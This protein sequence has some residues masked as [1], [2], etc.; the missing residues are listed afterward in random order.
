[1]PEPTLYYNEYGDW[2]IPAELTEW[3]LLTWCLERVYGNHEESEY[4]DEAEC[5]GCSWLEWCD[6]LWETQSEGSWCVREGM[7]VCAPYACSDR[8]GGYCGEMSIFD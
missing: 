2:Y 3:R 6:F 4:W 8:T 7:P 5:G 1:M